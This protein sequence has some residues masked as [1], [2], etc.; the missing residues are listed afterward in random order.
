M[1]LDITLYY[2][3]DGHKIPVDDLNITHNLTTMANKAHL[4]KAIW[5]P[6]KVNIKYAKDLI[7]ILSVGLHELETKPDYYKQFNPDNNWGS[8]DI[9]LIFIKVYLNLCKEYPNALIQADR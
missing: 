8:Y 9:L 3:N 2:I 4:Y 1:S 7:E 6:S 5:R